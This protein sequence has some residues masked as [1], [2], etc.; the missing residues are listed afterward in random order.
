MNHKTSQKRQAGLLK[1]G[2][3]PIEKHDDIDGNACLLEDTEQLTNGS[4]NLL[5]RERFVR[6]LEMQSLV[7]AGLK[8]LSEAI[9]LVLEVGK[10]NGR[11][12]G[13]GCDGSA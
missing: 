1:K 12:L 7:L 8:R 11:A 6:F 2:P 3:S 10:A 9:S 4:D 13:H 5:I